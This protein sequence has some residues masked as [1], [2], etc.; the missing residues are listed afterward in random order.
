M[1]PP[2]TPWHRSGIP[3]IWPSPSGPSKT[4]E[5]ARTFARSKRLYENGTPMTCWTR[6]SRDDSRPLPYVNLGSRLPKTSNHDFDAQND[7]GH[8]PPSSQSATNSKSR[9]WAVW[10][11]EKSSRIWAT[12]DHFTAL[13]EHRVH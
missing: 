1:M 7:R 4:V 8:C 5:W 11:E 3:G 2:Y 13:G 6:H 12:M 9:R 10:H